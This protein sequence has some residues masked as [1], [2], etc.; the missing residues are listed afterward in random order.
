MASTLTKPAAPSGALSGA[1]KWNKLNLI[2]Q[3]NSSAFCGRMTKVKN[4]QNIGLCIL[5]HSILPRKLKA[6]ATT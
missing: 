6:W 2:A 5:I 1:T 4:M 3:S